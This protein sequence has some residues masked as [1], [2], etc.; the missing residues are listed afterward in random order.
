MTTTIQEKAI[1]A[2][3]VSGRPRQ[4]ETHDGRSTT[5]MR[6]ILRTLLI[7]AIGLA[8]ILIIT[9]PNY[10]AGKDFIAY[11]SAGKLL[12]HH[13][14]PYS[15]SHVMALQKAQ[16]ATGSVPNI[17]RNPPWALFLAL[18]LGFVKPLVGLFFWIL[19]TVG[20]V[21]ASIRLLKVSS[22]DGAFGY[23]FAPVIACILV[24][25]SAQFLLLGFSLFLRFNRSRP[26]LAGVSLLFLAMK[27]HLFVVFWVILLVDCIYRRRFAVLAGGASAIAAASVFPLFFDPHV[28]QH[29][30]AM[31]HWAGLDSEV[32]P[33]VS[34]QL[35]ILIDSNAVWLLFVP[36]GIAVLWGIWYYFRSR[37]TWN[38][39]DNGL[40]LMLV[41]VA[42]SPYGWFTDETLL[43]PAIFG[44]LK[45]PTRPK[46][47]MWILLIANSVA[48]GI[49]FSHTSITSRGYLWT[50]LVWLAWYIYST[51]K[52]SQPHGQSD[53]PIELAE[54]RSMEKV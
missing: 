24:G 12:V 49:V 38:W 6:K 30:F 37:D 31:M 13:A 34:M 25:Q 42:C 43:L 27:P 36:S 45:S 3:K 32:F 40:L 26:F 2:D 5:P 4:Q 41:A 21:F 33:T 20:C 22:K 18:P 29:Y 35:R 50:P 10:V 48:I 51:R 19:V 11:W 28:W 44:G 39:E 14:D 23:V 16:G 8:A 1:P 17:M 52:S 47:S 46:Y 15:P 7:A 54:T 53:S 9:I